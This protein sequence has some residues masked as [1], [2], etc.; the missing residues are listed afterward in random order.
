VTALNVPPVN[1]ACYNEANYIRNFSD[2]NYD[3]VVLTT[4]QNLSPWPPT[5]AFQYCKG[6]EQCLEHTNMAVDGTKNVIED[7]KEVMRTPTLCQASC[8]CTSNLVTQRCAFAQDEAFLSNSLSAINIP[9]DRSS[10]PLFVTAPGAASSSL[11][12]KYD[13]RIAGC[14]TIH[15]CASNYRCSGASKLDDS[16]CNCFREVPT[17]MEIQTSGLSPKPTVPP[18]LIL[19][20]SSTTPAVSGSNYLESGSG[21]VAIDLCKPSGKSARCTFGD[22][23]SQDTCNT[24]VNSKAKLVQ[25]TYCPPSPLFERQDTNEE[26]CS[27]A[28][29]G[30]QNMC[31]GPHSLSSRYVTKPSNLNLDVAAFAIPD[32]DCWKLTCAANGPYASSHDTLTYEPTGFTGAGTITVETILTDLD[33]FAGA[34][35]WNYNF[36]TGW[37][38]N[39]DNIGML[40]MLQ[41]KV[42]I[43]VQYDES[44]SA[45]A[46]SYNTKWCLRTDTDFS[47]KIRPW[48]DIYPTPD[49]CQ[50]NGIGTRFSG[51][52][53][54][55]VDVSG[56]YFLHDTTTYPHFTQNRLL[57][58]TRTIFDSTE[59]SFTRR[60]ENFCMNTTVDSRDIN[61]CKTGVYSLVS[62]APC[63]PETARNNFIEKVSTICSVMKRNNVYMNTFCPKKYK[64][65]NTKCSE[66]S[67]DNDELI[68]AFEK[69]INGYKTFYPEWAEQLKYKCTK[70]VYSAVSND[71]CTREK[72]TCPYTSRDEKTMK[73]AGLPAAGF[74]P[75]CV[76]NCALSKSSKTYTLMKSNINIHSIVPSALSGTK[77]RTPQNTKH[78]SFKLKDVSLDIGPPKCNSATCGSN[79]YRVEIY[80][81][82]FVCLPCKVV[83]PKHCSGQHMCRFLKWDWAQ[84]P[85]RSS[86]A[87]VNSSNSF[88]DV[89]AAVRAN[90]IALLPSKVGL[91]PAWHDML[92]PYN[93]SSYNPQSLKTGYNDNMESIQGHCSRNNKLPV[94]TNCQNDVPRTTL[95]TFANTTYKVQDGSHIPTN[96]TLTWYVSRSQLLGTNIAAWHMAA[97]QA[98]FNELFNDTICKSGNI[99]NLVCLQNT[100]ANPVET[101]TVNPVLSGNFEVQ[102]GCD[103]VESDSSR[104]IDSVC[105]SVACPPSSTATYDMY[106][107]FSGTD[108]TLLQNQMRCKIRNGATAGY[109]STPKSFPT[110]LCAKRP[111]VPRSCDLRQGTLGHKT[112]DGSASSSVYSRLRWPSNVVPSGLLSGNNPIL[113][114][115]TLAAGTVSN[116]TMDP[117]DIG[118]HYIRM[119]LYESLAVTGFPLRSYTTLAEATSIAAVNWV[120]EWKKN[121]LTETSNMDQLYTLRTCTSWDCP[122]RRRYFWSGMGN[123]FRPTVPDPSRARVFYGTPTHPTTRPSALPSGTLANYKTRNGFCLC[124]AGDVCQPT[125]GPCSATETINSLSDLQ[126][127]SAQ[128]SHTDCPS[129]VDWPYTGG[130]MRD[131]TALTNSI[132]NCGILNRLPAFNYRYHNSKTIIPSDKTTLDEG[133]DCHM[134]RPAAY[135]ASSQTCTLVEKRSDSMVV[136]CGSQNVT[137]QRPKS[138]SVNVARRR[139]C[140]QCDPLPTFHASDGTALQE[141]EVSYG[142]LWRWAPSRKLAQDLRF[143]LCGNATS[144]PQLKST[145]IQDFWFNMMSGGL[146]GTPANTVEQLFKSVEPD[147]DD[148]SAKPWMLCTNTGDGPT[149][150]GSATKTAWLQN[151]SQTCSAIKDMP[152][153]NDAVTD[154]TVCDLDESLDN[155]CRVI[156]NARYRLFE[157]NCQ[158][159]GACRTSSFFYQ[160]ATFSISNDQL[161]RQTVQYFYDFTVP[162]SCPAMSEELELILEQNR[163]TAQECSAQSLEMFQMAIAAARQVVHFFVKIVYYMTE[164]WMNIISLI[165]TT[166][167]NPI[168]K[169]IM[170]NFNQLLNE[171]KQF[172]VTLGDTMYKMIMETGQLGKFIRDLVMTMC[173]FLKLLIGSVIQPITCFLKEFVVGL[174]DVIKTLANAIT[175][176]TLNLGV[177]D[178]WKK[179]VE[180]KFQCEFDNPFKCDNLFPDD[181]KGPSRLPMPTRCWVGYKPPVGD[182]KGLGCSASDTCMD[183]DGSF[184]ACGACSAGGSADRYGCDALTK[185]CRCHTVPIGRSQ[186]SSHQEC[187]VPDVECGFV[188]A[189]L[190]PSFGNVPCSRCSNKPV[191]LVTGSVGHCACTLRA[192][193]LQTC[194]A[195]YHAQRVSPDP[196]QLCLVSL[197]ISASSSSSYSANYRDL[198]STACANLNGAQTWC[199]NIWLDQGG[200]A[201]MAVGLSML[202]GRRLLSTGYSSNYTGWDGAYEPCRSLM[203]AKSLTVLET[204]VASDCERWRQIGERAILLYNLTNVSD[205]QFTSYLGIA[206]ANLKLEVY[207]FMMKYAEWVQPVLVVARRV[208]SS[209]APLFNQT[210]R[211][212]QALEAYPSLQDTVSTAHDLLPWFTF[213]QNQSRNSRRLLNWKD[214]LQAVKDYSVEL[215]NGNYANLNPTLAAEWNRGP[216]VWPPN[217]DY[218]QREHVCLVASI[219][220]NLTFPV[221]QSTISYYA[222]TGPPRPAVDRSF[223]G[224]LPVFATWQGQPPKNEPALVSTFKDFAKAWIDFSSIKAYTT[225]PD[226]GK[227]P[228]PFSEDLVDL[229]RCDFEK[230]Q[231]CT[232]H[233]RSLL[234][235]GVVVAIFFAIISFLFKLL[236]VPMADPLLLIAYVPTVMLYVFRF[237]VTCFPMLPTCF[238]GE[239]LHMAETLLPVSMTWPSELQKWP[240]CLEGA[241][242]PIGAYATPGTAECFRECTEWPFEYQT[243]EDNVAWLQCEAGYCDGSLVRDYY[244][245][246][247]AALPIPNPFYDMLQ[248]Q[249]Y[250]S[251]IERKRIYLDLP[252]QRDAQRLCCLFTVFN[253]VPVALA[254]VGVVAV[255][256]AAFSLAVALF[257]SLVA[258]ALTLVAF[259]HSP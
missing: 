99:A 105:N 178:E 55:T 239:L 10:F 19:S 93:F 223:Q 98:Y 229:I 89:Y 156:Q 88:S 101:M 23:V 79:F 53:L 225:S 77:P 76:Q 25:D 146:T 251:A 151:R 236:N 83:P 191:C 117:W 143:R 17:E 247:V 246:W 84:A 154:L 257:R 138:A 201:Y 221:L 160:P 227:S 109:L 182:Q 195:Q 72:K 91:K 114:G 196:V 110:N 61:K 2:P 153:A 87:F 50:F 47:K 65:G 106:N 254:A 174:I 11:D 241:P 230:V 52:M 31:T 133:G 152:N 181:N 128:T 238:M 120:G 33:I 28:L 131:G 249:R 200:S 198:A 158:L 38:K 6:F 44:A 185:L 118:G 204:H 121:L 167:P 66:T 258:L 163:R 113:G 22:P 16:Q 216:F 139:P 220:F 127:R 108:Y 49:V 145:S 62:S 137:L 80:K 116:I 107:T 208:I 233:N 78:L 253:V 94:F 126:Y 35:N 142:K 215:A 36:I 130:T 24:A 54:N 81:G 157:A 8:K 56:N 171:F 9:K 26:M 90:L 210:A 135:S 190:Q 119:R 155:L 132:S 75:D 193:S 150:H 43:Y 250:L 144:C 162:G 173:E 244:Q 186:C 134:G 245:P 112:F 42:Q 71:T 129:Q 183:D 177:M 222:K 228:S 242:A 123:Q 240:G 97:R 169:L 256:L 67:A 211:L 86:S 21:W 27:S 92:E 100:L 69:C 255:V 159:S 219:T 231:H 161:A 252:G 3:A 115:S 96:H 218:W 102:E 214:N 59:D 34:M 82:M 197:G 170:T 95:K 136:L 45:K 46:L 73:D 235:G 237:S 206:E 7:V 41:T 70:V 168:I 18:Y 58:M 207:L 15:C 85:D 187:Y 37:S 194:P 217:Y 166:D 20:D 203:A 175:F 32:V 4:V 5:Q 104:V 180:T 125:T 147:T 192:T 209:M 164:I 124:L 199:L 149:C 165:M 68:P 74:C 51:T 226:G 103:V 184:T 259:V 111:A 243:W 232:A 14:D 30:E 40:N 213:Q 39:F 13:A 172:F 12:S 148:W 189:Y 202:Q 57:E 140:T 205:V 60:N 1:L 188:D 224:A 63:D 122:L 29:E 141:P 179:V 234:W 248:M 212:L 48:G 64:D 176:G